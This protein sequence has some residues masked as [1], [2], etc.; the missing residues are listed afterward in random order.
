MMPTDGIAAPRITG[1][2]AVWVYEGLSWWRALVV[3]EKGGY[4][5]VRLDHGVTLPV[6]VAELRPRDPECNG[7]DRPQTKR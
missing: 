1:G 2:S 3:H 6:N 7:A 4:C 5:I